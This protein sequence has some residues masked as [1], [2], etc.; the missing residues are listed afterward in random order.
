MTIE[1]WARALTEAV[2]ARDAA[3]V[4]AL[5]LP[6]GFWR[7]FLAL[8]GTLQTVEG[9]GAIAA[10]SFLR[11][12]LRGC[13]GDGLAALTGG[14]A[15]AGTVAGPARKSPDGAPCQTHSRA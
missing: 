12:V 8:G 13:A 6:G 14:R 11:R 3:A 9:A 1:T 5:F 4:E 7:D 10:S 15:I 2:A